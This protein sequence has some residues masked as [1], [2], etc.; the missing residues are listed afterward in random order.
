MNETA[1]STTALDPIDAEIR[2]QIIAFIKEKSLPVK[3]VTMTVGK[4]LVPFA[5][6]TD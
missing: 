6:R 1:I 4:V 3:L 5:S 2:D